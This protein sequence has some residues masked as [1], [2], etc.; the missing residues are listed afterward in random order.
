MFSFVLIL[1]TIF[2]G[3]QVADSPLFISLELILNLM[4]GIDFFCRLKL[5][6]CRKYFRNP[7][8]NHLQWWNLF[9]AIVVTICILLFAVTLFAK[10]G[11]IKG[12]EEAAEETLLVMWSIWQ[13]LRMIL[14]AKKQ[15]LAQ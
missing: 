5:V 9:D 4:I 7:A 1:V 2:D 11:A 6:G 14:I 3:F 13:T 12:F 8:T 10:T 15:R